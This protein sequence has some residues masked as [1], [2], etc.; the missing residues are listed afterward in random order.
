ME[1]AIENFTHLLILSTITLLE[2]PSSYHKLYPY[3]SPNPVHWYEMRTHQSPPSPIPNPIPVHKRSKH[4]HDKPHF[5]RFSVPTD[6]TNSA[7][8][9]KRACKTDGRKGLA[10]WQGC[11][12]PCG[13]K[14][15]RRLVNLTTGKNRNELLKSG[16]EVLRHFVHCDYKS[17]Q[18]LKNSLKL[19]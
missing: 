17:I 18:F 12:M 5:R 4:S 2:T 6:V 9:S 7:L 14:R 16:C 19:N 3:T 13:S 10:G 15:V 11:R 1:T 8:A